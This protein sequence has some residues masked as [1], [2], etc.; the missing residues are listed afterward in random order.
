MYD[1]SSDELHSGRE[2]PMCNKKIKCNLLAAVLIL[3]VL[4]PT[5]QVGKAV[6]EHCCFLISQKLV[7]GS[8]V[9]DL[10]ITIF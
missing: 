2:G 6:I 1:A 5:V 10:L 7:E 3:T 8:E 9:R 4:P